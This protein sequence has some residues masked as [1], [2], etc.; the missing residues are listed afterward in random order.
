VIEQHRQTQAYR[1]TP[2]KSLNPI[3]NTS[4]LAQLRQSLNYL[5]L[6]GT[7][8]IGIVFR[9]DPVRGVWIGWGVFM[10]LLLN[11]VAIPLIEKAPQYLSGIS[12]FVV[13]IGSLAGM[14]VET[15]AGWLLCLPSQD[16]GG[17]LRPSALAA[18]SNPCLGGR[19][20][21]NGDPAFIFF[22]SNA[23]AVPAQELVDIIGVDKG[24]TLVQGNFA[25]DG[26]LSLNAAIYN[27]QG[28]FL[29]E[30]KS[31]NPHAVGNVC[32]K[33]PDLS[34][35]IVQDFHKNELL[36]VRYLNPHAIEVRGLFAYPMMNSLRVTS[37][38]VT[39][40][41]A[42]GASPMSVEGNC[43]EYITERMLT[44]KPISN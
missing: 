43:F 39:F 27:S 38:A 44:L 10:L 21:T 35:F 40:P 41:D 36:Y 15:V 13:L 11:H 14:Y 29:A 5:A 7:P 16:V 26:S 42:S 20:P 28:V 17:V 33:R 2:T 9:I 1:Q 3:R 18:P 12:L 4:M 6:I 32:I 19:R 23:G 25:S 31:D 24:P 8:T 30:I 22:G 37:N 34:T